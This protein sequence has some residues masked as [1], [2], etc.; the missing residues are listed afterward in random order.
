MTCSGDNGVIAHRLEIAD[1]LAVDFAVG[2]NGRDVVARI[3]AAVLGHLAEIFRKILEHFK[4]LLRCQGRVFHALLAA[5]HVLIGV[6][7]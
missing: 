6:A 2:N 7:E 4:E 5:R 1:F 3:L